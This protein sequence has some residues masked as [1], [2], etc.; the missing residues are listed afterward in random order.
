MVHQY[1]Q[2]DGHGL[3]IRVSFMV[4]VCVGGGGRFG[5]NGFVT[6]MQPFPID[7]YYRMNVIS[8]VGSQRSDSVVPLMLRTVCC[9]MVRLP[10]LYY[11]SLETASTLLRMDNILGRLYC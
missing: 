3:T 10:A 8:G 2:Y 5:S 11:R 7:G 6:K 4:N 9:A 1:V